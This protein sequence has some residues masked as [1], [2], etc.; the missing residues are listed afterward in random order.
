MSTHHSYDISTSRVIPTPTYPAIVV[1]ND[2]FLPPP[3]PPQGTSAAVSFAYGL[4]VG[5]VSVLIVVVAFIRFFIFTD[6]SSERKDYVTALSRRDQRNAAKLMGA[7]NVPSENVINTILEKTYYNV[8][9]HNAESVDW[10]TVLIAQVVSQFREDARADDSML[11]SLNDLLNGDIIPDFIDKIRVTEL[12]IGDDYPIFSN[13]KI[14]YNRN[15]LGQ[16]QGQDGL[17]AQIDVD[18]TDTVT[19]GIETRLLLNFPKALFAVLP[20]SL[21]VSIVR[22]SGTLSVSLRKSPAVPKAPNTVPASSNRSANATSTSNS[23]D[24]NDG[25]TY[26]SFS[27]DPNYRLEF[28][29]KSLVGARSRLQ[30]IPKIGQFIE[31]RLRKWFTDRCVS[32][33]CQQIPLPSFWPRSKTTAVVPPATNANTNGTNNVNPSGV[34]GLPPSSPLVLPVDVAE[35]LRRRRQSHLEVR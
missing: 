13:C 24:A 6:T 11:R 14:L 23:D 28:D 1:A 21:S 16:S 30:D 12:N 19:L 33:R 3:T 35:S 31:S 22:F 32:P 34:N 20:V 10:F 18:L 25:T 27:F 15:E 5:Q 2:D 26:L 17:E 7:N 29:I 4:L 8:E 9:T